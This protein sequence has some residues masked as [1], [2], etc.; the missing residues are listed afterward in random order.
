[1]KTFMLALVAI[2]TYLASGQELIYPKSGDVVYVGETI[3]I[4]WKS[5]N[6]VNE[7]VYISLSTTD[8]SYI[9]VVS[10]YH[11]IGSLKWKV[12]TKGLKGT[13]F[14]L[15]MYY[16]VPPF[17]SIPIKILPGKRPATTGKILEQPE[18]SIKK[19]VEV[20]WNSISNAYYRVLFRDNLTNKPVA[21]SSLI[22]GT[23]EIMSYLASTDGEIG[24][25]SV[26]RIQ[27][28]DFTNQTHVNFVSTNSEFIDTSFTNSVFLVGNMN[29][30]NFMGSN[31]NG[32]TAYWT[33]FSDTA[34][35]Y[36]D[37]RDSAFY[38]SDFKR[39]NLVWTQKEN[40]LFVYCDFTGANLGDL[41]GARFIM[42]IMP[43]GSVRDY[44]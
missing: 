2:F 43:D 11:D 28:P 36:S 35:T 6:K 24:M 13:D 5:Q 25:Y 34:F 17:F 21:V 14:I 44:P 19:A 1:M 20:K 33:S 37:M 27:N 40:S 16:G 22:V 31:M 18:V 15:S 8:G 30:S 42:C 41:T 7:S 38:F 29:G 26:E 10:Y 23:G 4:K 3:T 12:D 9:M 32:V 39:S